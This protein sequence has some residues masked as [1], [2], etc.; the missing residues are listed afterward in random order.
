MCNPGGRGDF[1][2]SLFNDGR[3]NL[4]KTR[5]LERII[6]SSRGKKANKE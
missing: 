1:V 4:G 5:M 3:L 2:V 6:I